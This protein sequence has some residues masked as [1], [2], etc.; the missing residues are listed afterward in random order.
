MLK[1]N[2]NI[3][4]LNNGI[5]QLGAQISQLNKGMV[6][7]QIGERVFSIPVV[8]SANV[9]PNALQPV[10]A[11]WF[12]RFRTFFLNHVNGLGISSSLKDVTSAAYMGKVN[13]LIK[14]LMVAHKYYCV[15]SEN[16]QP[17]ARFI[18]L[19]KKQVTAEF[20]NDVTAAY[21]N[22]VKQLGGSRA[23]SPITQQVNAAAFTGGIETYNWQTG[24]ALTKITLF[25]IPKSQNGISVEGPGMIRKETGDLLTAAPVQPNTGAQ[26]GPPQKQEDFNLPV[27]QTLTPTTAAPEKGAVES[28]KETAEKE[29]TIKNK[30]LWLWIAGALGAGYILNRK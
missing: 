14:Q 1:S 22:V 28:L 16:G 5:A 20:V 7:R 6:V 24:Q 26:T 29:I 23:V 27:K 10:N 12:P 13:D 2:D 11:A 21:T 4:L 25:A 8:V 17:A 18:A 15:Q 9:D 3:Q 19:V 30:S